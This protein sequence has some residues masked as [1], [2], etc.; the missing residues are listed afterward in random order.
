MSFDSIF[1][2]CCPHL[3]S[4]AIWKLCEWVTWIMM[5]RSCCTGNQ[6][7]ISIGLIV[8]QQQFRRR[9]KQAAR[10]ER[11]R[12]KL[13]LDFDIYFVLLEWRWVEGLFNEKQKH[14]VHTDDRHSKT[15]WRIFLCILDRFYLISIKLNW[16]LNEN[17]SGIKKN[18][19]RWGMKYSKKVTVKW[20]FITVHGGIIRILCV[21]RWYDAYQMIN[22]L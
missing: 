15:L 6:F 18:E 5:L 8:A 20:F 17:S 12:K 22:A 10:R 11:P 9:T 14:C 2:L 21:E 13:C 3:L 1:F 7:I 16:K 4:L 19:M